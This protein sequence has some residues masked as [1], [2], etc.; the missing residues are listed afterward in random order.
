MLEIVNCERKK[1]EAFFLLLPDGV[2]VSSR[3]CCLCVGLKMTLLPYKKK[4]NIFF[5]IYHTTKQENN[6]QTKNK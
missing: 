1:N 4:E 3:E 5:C 6:K 2:K